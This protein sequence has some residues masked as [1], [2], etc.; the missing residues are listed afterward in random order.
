MTPMEVAAPALETALLAVV[1]TGATGPGGSSLGGGG[2]AT[3]HC[4]GGSG[5]SSVG[6]ALGPLGM[7]LGPFAEAFP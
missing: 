1:V 5:G 3:S 4:V 6:F 7:K 2:A